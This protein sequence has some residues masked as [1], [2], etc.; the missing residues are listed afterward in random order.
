MSVRLISGIY[1]RRSI[2]TPPTNKTHPMSERA[3]VAIFNILGNSVISGAYVLDAFAGSGALGLEALSRG[4]SH[5]TFV[6]KN[7]IAANIIRENCQNL[8]IPDSSYNVINTTINNWL[9]TATPDK[10]DLIFADP[11]YHDEQLSTVSKITGLLKAH[12]YMILSYT[13][14]SDVEIDSGIVVVDNRSYANA[15]VTFYHRAE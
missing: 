8:G 3:R 9:S 12:G 6:E 5:V 4:A 11:P 15:H 14:R 7:K 13:G 1:G 2:A 10:F